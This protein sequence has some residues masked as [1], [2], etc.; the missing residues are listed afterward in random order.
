MNKITCPSKYVLLIQRLLR[1]CGI[2]S[3]KVEATG[4]LS[5]SMCQIEFNCEINQL[6]TLENAAIIIEKKIVTM[7]GCFENDHLGK[8]A[9]KRERSSYRGINSALQLMYIDNLL[10]EA[11]IE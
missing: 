1:S 2:V 5:D 8:V 7:Y 10:N 3:S 9:L 11:G 6:E 4:P